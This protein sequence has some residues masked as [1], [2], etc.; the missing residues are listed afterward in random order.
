[1][2]KFEEF[3]GVHLEITNRCQASCP[4]CPRNIHSG[5]ENP[6]LKINDWTL[7]NFKQIFNTEVLTQIKYI[8]FC[9]NFGDP[10]LNNDLIEMC[11]YSAQTNPL[12]RLIIH[13][14]GSARST[15]WWEEL[16]QVLPENHKVVFALDGLEDTHHLYRVGTFFNQ[17][18]KNA[19]TFIQSN[20]IAE[21]NFIRFH[22]NQHQV[23]SAEQ[24]A[25]ELGFKDFIVKDSKRFSKPFPVIKDNKIAYHIK[26]P[27]DSVV[28][29]VGKSDVIH[30]TSWKD[31][32][33]VQCFVQKDKEIYIDAHFMTLP[34][35]MMAAFLYMNYDNEILKKHNIYLDDH[36]NDVAIEVQAQVWNITKELGGTNV[37]ERGIKNLISSDVWQT[38]W[39]YKWKTGGSSTCIIMCSPSSPYISIE[40]QKT[41]KV[42]FNNDV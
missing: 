41:K 38:L 18:I 5:I 12:I 30:H 9:G 21:W 32:T 26:Q 22:H 2:F 35:C 33:C 20:G 14:N 36:V 8:N 34:C 29:F 39:D 15:N 1:M 23:E 27:I 19:K 24:L 4:M 11:R 7:D 42:K 17:I 16:A 37:L 31:A 10:I 40:D 6:L 13:T 25:K 28:K 3:N